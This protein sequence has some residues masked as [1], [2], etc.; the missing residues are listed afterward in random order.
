MFGFYIPLIIAYEFKLNMRDNF[1][2]KSLFEVLPIIIF[3][4]EILIKINTS[5][6]YKVLKKYNIKFFFFLNLNLL[7]F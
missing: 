2:S 3:I 5:Y 4:F 1:I 7:M 6:Y